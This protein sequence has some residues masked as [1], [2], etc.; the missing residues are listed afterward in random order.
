MIPF[1]LKLDPFFWGGT[2]WWTF[3]GEACF[4]F[5]YLNHLPK[6]FYKNIKTRH[7][8]PTG[9]KKRNPC[10]L[11]VMQRPLK[12]IVVQPGIVDEINPYQK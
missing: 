12:P 6:K 2:N 5:F 9:E 10:S 11:E 8:A 4:T 1:L 3:S 7:N